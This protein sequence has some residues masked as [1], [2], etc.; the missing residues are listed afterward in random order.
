M[1]LIWS[2]LNP[3]SAAAM[4]RTISAFCASSISPFTTIVQVLSLM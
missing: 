1:I 3:V 2:A 4:S